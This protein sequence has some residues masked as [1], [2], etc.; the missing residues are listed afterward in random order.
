MLKFLEAKTYFGDF[1]KLLFRKDSVA[2]PARVVG[3]FEI[4]TPNG[5]RNRVVSFFPESKRFY[6]GTGNNIAAATPQQVTIFKNGVTF[7]REEVLDDLHS[8]KFRDKR[9]P[10]LKKRLKQLDLLV[11]EL[12]E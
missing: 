4:D 11:E 5:R 2:T 12:G 8:A 3:S 6:Y 1:L 7:A 10:E 9:V